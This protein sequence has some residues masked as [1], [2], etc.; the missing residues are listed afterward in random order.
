MRVVVVGAGIAGLALAGSLQRRGHEVTVLEEAGELRTGG[1]AIAI[2]HNGAAALQ[3]LGADIAAQGRVIEL[4]EIWT[5]KG[6]VV[7]RVDAARLSRQHGVEAVTIPCEGLLLEVLAAQVRPGTIAF[8]A[9][10]QRVRQA[11]GSATVGGLSG[12][13]HRSR[14]RSLGQMGTARPCG[15]P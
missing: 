11:E 8:A 5:C 12:R 4:L 9:P 10:C 13:G 3:R 6:R 14:P 15:A 1:A 7:G 2:W